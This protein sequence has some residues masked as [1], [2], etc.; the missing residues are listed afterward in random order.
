MN[1]E[2]KNTVV[3]AGGGTFGTSIAERL[4][5][6]PANRVIIHS[7]EEDVVETINKYHKNNKYFPTRY[8]N[9]SIKATGDFNIF[10]EADVIFLVIPSKFIISFSKQMKDY[11]PEDKH[12]LVIN[13]AKGMSDE[14]AFITENI[15]FERTA[16][17]K[18]PSFAIE[19][20]NGFPTAFTFGG[21]KKDYNYLKN[22]LLP[23]T[24][25]IIDHTNDVRAVELSSILKNMYAI[26]I[27]L[28][29]G[30]YNSPNVD[31][32]VYT[33]AVNEMRGIMK[34][35]GCNEDIMYRYC[36]IGDLGLTGLNDLSRNRT[37]GMLIG[38]GFSYDQH[39]SATTI[40]GHR[41]TK[42]MGEVIKEAGLE[43]EFPLLTALYKMMFEKYTLND[44]LLAVFK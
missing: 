5:W 30:R 17:M 22:E 42:L 13:L 1:I 21:S 11:I 28:V 34:L 2:T 31:Y 27:G 33:K 44:Y 43:E 12:P 6:N 20:L 16:S 35:Y 15:P 24:S 25:L 38:K 41:T 26:A 8:L 37:L 10:S 4:A 39:S 40:E 19:V 29:S 9:R 18:G 32:L 7:I 36:A 14:G 3:V 23:E